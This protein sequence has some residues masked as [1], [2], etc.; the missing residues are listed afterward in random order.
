MRRSRRRSSASSAQPATGRAARAGSSTRSQG[1]R[2]RRRS[3]PQASE[4]RAPAE[5]LPPTIAAI[6]CATPPC[7]SNCWP[8]R[9]RLLPAEPPQGGPRRAN[10]Y[11]AELVRLISALRDAS[12]DEVSLAS[13]S[14]QIGLSE[15]QVSRLFR[16]EFGTTFRDHLATLRLER[17]KRL[18]AATDLPVI[19]VAGSTGWSSLAHFN[20]VFRRRVGLTPSAFRA[21]ELAFPTP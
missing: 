17:A 16:E 14:H 18:L 13:L 19:E 11:R 3:E 1:R 9:S 15:R 10:P 12:L 7:V 2:L 8:S 4:G 20:A 6:G 5:A 21:G